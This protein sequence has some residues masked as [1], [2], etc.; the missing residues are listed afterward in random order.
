MEWFIK[1]NATLPKL[2]VKIVKDGR[3][4]YGEFLNDLT[5]SSV[6]FSMIDAET[7]IPKI[8]S[9]SAEIVSELD[10]DGN[11]IHYVVYKFSKKDTNKT[12]R[13]QTEFLIKNSDGN[14]YLPLV[15]N[16]YINIIDSFSLDDTE[17]VDNYVIEFPC[18]G[19]NIRPETLTKY[20]STEDG[21]KLVTNQ[22]F[23]ATT[24]YI[25]TLNTN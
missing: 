15:D 2:T 7:Q 10:I 3:N 14:T 24:K 11:T 5:E 9:K 21:L 19:P 18:C 6:F 16:L 20:L 17:F 8:T 1:K 4:T 13:Y 25:I 23:S 12:G 22:G